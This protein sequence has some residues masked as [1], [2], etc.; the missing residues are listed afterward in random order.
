MLTSHTVSQNKEEVSPRIWTSGW[1][2]AWHPAAGCAGAATAR[3]YAPSPSWGA[4]KWWFAWCD[5]RSRPAPS[6]RHDAPSYRQAKWGK[7]KGEREK[8]A[9]WQGDGLKT[10]ASQSHYAIFK[11]M[12]PSQWFYTQTVTGFQK[13]N[14]IKLHLMSSFVKKERQNKRLGKYMCHIS[15]SKLSM[16]QVN[17]APGLA[18][19]RPQ[20]IHM[21]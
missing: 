13:P 2:A 9:R 1:T 5:R 17:R 3:S 4:A 12:N 15:L 14:M 18:T 6:G 19:C 7:A 8:K 20:Q 21:R 11:S 16:W 10:E